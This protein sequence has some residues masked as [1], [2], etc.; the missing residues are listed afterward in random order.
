MRTIKNAVCRSGALR[1]LML[2]AAGV[3]CAAVAGGPAGA[4]ALAA[5]EL[6]V[7]DFNTGDKPNNLGGDFGSWDRDPN[8]ETQKINL[9]F[10]ED[11]STGDKY[12]Y[13]VRLDYDV[14]SP[15]PAYNGFW[16]K[17]AGQDA[18]AFNTLN[19][20]LKGDKDKG[21]TPRLKLE[22][23]DSSNKPS[24]YI[25]SG[26]TEDWQKFSVP[27][28]KFRKIES[29]NSMNEFVLVF[30]DVNSNPKT[31]AVYLDNVSFSKE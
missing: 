11:D 27:F 4:Q 1:V 26:I 23:K 18:T 14:D 13:S 31:G 9:A 19:F 25:V 12:G 28:D 8:D 5:G 15:N 2:G 6:V 20:W 29:W 3:F 16:M 22:L 30:D 7:A 17:L 21:Y 24:P 10:V